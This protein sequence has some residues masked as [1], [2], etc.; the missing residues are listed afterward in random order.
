[1]RSLED[2]P[3]VKLTFGKREKLCG[4]CTGQV[5]LEAGDEKPLVA[6]PAGVL[7]KVLQKPLAYLDRV[8]PSFPPDGDVTKLVIERGG[9][10]F[11]IEKET[12]ESKETKDQPGKE[13]KVPAAPSW[14]L[15]KP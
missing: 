8:L 12:K 11:E 13:P 1:E 3:N 6:A 14:K 4:K 2:E 10:T 15:K 7:D 9:Q 5:G